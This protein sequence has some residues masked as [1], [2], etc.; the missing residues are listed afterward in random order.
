MSLVSAFYALY[1]KCAGG[2]GGARRCIHVF[3]ALYAKHG[4]GACAVFVFERYTQNT[5]SLEYAFYAKYGGGASCAVY[6]FK[7]YKQNT[8]NLYMHF[9]HT[10]IA[11]NMHYMHS[12]QNM[13]GLGPYA[14]VYM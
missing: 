8:Y 1:G 4:G 14:V 5:Y 13:R 11:L 2:G 7:R 3:D 6:V 12:M 9:M 10:R